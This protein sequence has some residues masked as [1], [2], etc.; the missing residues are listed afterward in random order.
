MHEKY[1]R[2]GLAVVSVRVDGGTGRTAAMRSKALD[3]LTEQHAAFTNLWLDEDMDLWT[4]KLDATPPIVFV[5]GRDG[6]LA[7]KV[8]GA[9]KDDEVEKLVQGLLKK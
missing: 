7:G 5:I 9:G 8:E 1:A 4:G 3:F 6:R 2:D